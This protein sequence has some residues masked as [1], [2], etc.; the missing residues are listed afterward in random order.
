MK[1]IC[2][3]TYEDY[4]KL[5]TN[6]DINALKSFN[7]L[8][9]EYI[10]DFVQEI[11]DYAL[12]TDFDE[13]GISDL[14]SYSNINKGVIL[15]CP[16]IGIILENFFTIAN[17]HPVQETFS[18]TENL[19]K[20]ISNSSHVHL[21]MKTLYRIIPGYTFCIY[22][23]N[24]PITYIHSTTKHHIKD[25]IKENMIRAT[26]HCDGTLGR[27][28]YVYPL[29]LGMIEHR[30][31]GYIIKDT[32]N[33]PYLKLVRA[34]GTVRMTGEIVLLQD[35]VDLTDKVCIY[36]LEEMEAEMGK[37]TMTDS[38]LIEYFG[39]SYMSDLVT[40]ILSE[41]VNTNMLYIIERLLYI[42]CSK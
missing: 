7:N 33:G 8:P 29:G 15:S 3:N 19:F 9:N 17:R 16:Y 34:F 31:N 2:G 10:D 20:A 38:E 13:L 4:D 1:D 21:L 22:V 6:I 23:D 36:N 11:Y 14:M 27:G 37:T 32:Y 25:I 40:N 5:L 12:Y 24:K 41:T 28:V 39:L 26:K 18:I 35:S 42:I 30:T